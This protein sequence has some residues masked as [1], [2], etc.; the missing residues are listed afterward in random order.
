MSKVKIEAYIEEEEFKND[1]GE[2]VKFLSLQLPV[3]DNSVKRIKV[4][5]FILQLAKE[6]A[7][8]QVA[9]PFGRK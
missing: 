3:T 5:Q 7:E 6:R 1:K 8:N 9:S 2:N 4:E